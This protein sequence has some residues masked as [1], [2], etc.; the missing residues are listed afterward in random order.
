MSSYTPVIVSA[1]R[2]YGFDPKVLVRVNELENSGRATFDIN[3]WDSNATA[4]TPSGGPFQF[5]E[6]TFDAYAR[7]AKA[8]NPAAWQGVP[9]EWRNPQAQALAAAWAMKNGKGSAWTTFKRARA[10]A[11]SVRLPTTSATSITPAAST[12][13]SPS[14]LVGEQVVPRF[15]AAQRAT[16]GSVFASQPWMAG[17]VANATKRVPVVSAPQPVAAPRPS[18]S[19]AAPA[20][21]KVPAAADYRWLQRM[22]QQLF[23]LENDPGNSQT[24]GG[25]HTAGSEHYE[26]RAIDFG[27][28]RN[29]RKQLN[30]WKAWAKKQGLDV[31]DEGDHIHVSIAGGGV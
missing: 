11:G 6:P 26:D 21:G 10:S 7:E 16:L 5:I 31:L 23:G 8:A 24:T 13:S 30:A 14:V 22:G 2:A 27:T 18:A 19:R 20:G 17:L 29:D 3:D 15:N 12:P 4:G 9:L 28:A 25:R 1:A